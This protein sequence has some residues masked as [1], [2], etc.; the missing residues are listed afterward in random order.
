MRQSKRILFCLLALCGV[1][2]WAGPAGS[3]DQG[4]A[5]I[6]AARMEQD[7]LPLLSVAIGRK[8]TVV[9]A[10]AI[11]LADL[12]NSV[13]ASTRTVYRIGSVSKTVTSTAVMQLVE[14]DRLALDVPVQQYCPSFP[15]KGAPITPRLLLAHLSGIRD[16]NYRRFTE[17]FLSSKRYASVGEALAVFKRHYRKLP[18]P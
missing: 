9:Y 4:P 3:Q 14:R 11:G 5:G 2:A 17:E 8:G 1:L 15:D 13:P 18:R 7:R 16:Y 12:E 6:V 10:G